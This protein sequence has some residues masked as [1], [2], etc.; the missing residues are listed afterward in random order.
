[1]NYNDRSAICQNHRASSTKMFA[2][3]DAGSERGHF[4]KPHQKRGPRVHR[5]GS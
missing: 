3:S 1:M 4:Q 5:F 2:R